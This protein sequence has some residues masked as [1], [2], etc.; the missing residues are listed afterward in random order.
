MIGHVFGHY[1]VIE[2]IGSGGM[3][4]VYRA[5]DL[6]LDRFVA[7][8]ILPPEKVADAERKRRFVQEAKAASALNHSN[9]VHIYD[10][11][12]EE[13]VDYIAMEHIKGNT[14]NER[15][16]HRG[17]Q[18]KDSLKY[19]VQIADALAKAHSVGI[20]HRDLKPSNIMVNEDDT[21]KILD[22]GL[23]KLLE[24]IQGDEFASTVTDVA[25]EKPVTG[26][27]TVVGTVA[28][29]SPEQ[30]EGKMVDPRSDIFT[31]GTVL[32][33]MVT[34]RRAFT[35]SNVFSTLS[36]ILSKAPAPLDIEIPHDLG[37]I[38]NRCLRKDPARRFQN[39]ADL[40]VAL[41]ELKEESNSHTLTSITSAVNASSTLHF[42]R[43]TVI[44]LIILIIVVIGAVWF[45]IRPRSSF[46]G[47]VL[48]SGIAP[49]GDLSLLIYSPGG[50]FNPAL[51]PDGKMLAFV[52]EDQGR[53]D[54]FVSRVAGGENIRLTNDDVEESL[55]RFSPDG[56]RILFTRLGSETR[57]S[58]ICIIPTLG[59]QPI[60][61]INNGLSATWAPDGKQLAFVLRQPGEG[62]A[63]AVSSADGTDISLVLKSNATYPF[64]RTPSWSPDGK[65]LAVTRSMGGSAGEI[66]LV[67][68]DGSPPR[69]LSNDPAGIFSQMPVF[70]PDG[71]GVVHQS[72][73]A[74]ATN[75]WILPLDNG[76]PVRLTSGP[77][78]DIMP[79]VSHDGSIAFANV[80]TLASLIIYNLENGQSR[81]ILTHS[82]T[83]WAPAFSPS[84]RELAFSRTEQDGT[85]RIWIVAVQGGPPRQLTSGVLPE[86]YPRFTPDGNSV[87]YN[88]WSSETDQIWSVPKTGGPPRAL[89]STHQNDTQYADISPDGQWIAFTRAE[90][91]ES[92]IYIAAIDNGEERRLTEFT[93]TLPRWSPDGQWIAFTRSRGI[94]DGIFV[95]KPDG[96]GM[97]QLSETGGWPVW[98][99]DGKQLGYQSY[100][101]DGSL[102]VS[103]IPLEGG[104]SKTFNFIRYRSTNNPFDISPDG[105][106]LATTDRKVVSS[107]IWLLKPR[108]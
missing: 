106:R 85:W 9:I 63:L 77:G 3:G 18:L 67:S 35:G 93:S 65:H 62:D 76:Q 27:G 15:I 19:A 33:E 60:H 32:Y 29:M 84:G 50:A 78:P 71:R 8:K 75:L 47:D 20:I 92:H 66:W 45:Y 16:G 7:L 31:F 17:L 73:R 11:N 59:G 10:I 1:Q 54:L 36:A 57:P 53:M 68:L 46:D 64:F 39:M 51:S 108:S 99:P 41:E 22:F 87:V 107:D 37:R 105:T 13:G 4:V 97:R 79:S 43:R 28:Y 40:K 91:G 49:G 44:S 14:L 6:H 89:M 96:T 12:T 24:K 98:W 101:K 83:L 42:S 70:T 86:V 100:G 90:A 82:S 34:G 55:P 56:E 81:E 94:I 58:E 48:Q 21:I 80:R 88:T 102:E 61:L 38:I 25:E 30:V 104:P 72:N 74:G 95:I 23:A 26:E 5:R 2:E 103:T 69:R 52:A